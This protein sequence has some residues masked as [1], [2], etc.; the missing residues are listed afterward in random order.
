[1]GAVAPKTNKK[2]M[3]CIIMRNV[4]YKDRRVSQ[5]QLVDILFYLQSVV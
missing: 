3:F 4:G 5:T 1:M 2:N